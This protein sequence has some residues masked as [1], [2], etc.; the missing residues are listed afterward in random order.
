MFTGISENS[1]GLVFTSTDGETWTTFHPGTGEWL[2][3]VTYGGD[4]RF[5]VAGTSLLLIR[6]ADSTDN[7]EDDGNGGGGNGGF[8]NVTAADL[9]KPVWPGALAVTLMAIVL[10]FMRRRQYN[11]SVQ[12]Y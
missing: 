7:G 6:N 2:V 5:Y 11:Y 4:G 9:D 8:C 1:E 12:N 10:L 3:G